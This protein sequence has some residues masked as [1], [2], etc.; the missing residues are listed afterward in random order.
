M[1]THEILMKLKNGELSVK[2]AEGH[3]RRQPFEELGYAKIDTHRKL[4]SG[5]PEVVFCSGKADEHL[6]EIFGKIYEM[7]GEVFGTRASKRQYELLK[8]RYPDV[9][10][11]TV[12]GIIKIENPGKEK[13]GCITVCTAGTSDIAVAEEAAQT[14]E[15]F[16]SYVERVYDVGVSGLHRLLANLDTIQKANCIIAVAGMEGALASVIGG[17]VDKPVIAVPTSVGYG[18]NLKGLS[19]LLTMINSC[20]NGIAVVNIDN[21]YGAGY[22]ASQINRLGER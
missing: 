21:G 16:G 17:L 5:F 6:L 1:D 7:E 18:A 3:L 8:E 9:Q 10:Y 22:I 11:D 12:S 14:A 20:A 13:Q 2:E 15:Y 19:A 4:R